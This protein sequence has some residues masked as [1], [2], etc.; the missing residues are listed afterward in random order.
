[1]KK[2]ERLKKDSRIFSYSTTAHGKKYGVNFYRTVQG[3]KISLRQ[4]GFTNSTDAIEWADEAER[5]IYLASGTAKRVTVSEYYS[6]WM[7]RNEAYWSPDTYN[8]YEQKFEKYLLPKFGKAKLRDV[9]RESF[10]NYIRELETVER[11]A[12]RIGYSSKTISTLRGYMSTMLNDAVYSG[13]IPS[14]KLR[15]LR[16]KAGIGVRNNEISKEKYVFAIKTAQRV[17][18]P[19]ALAAF[20]LSLVALRHAEILGMQPKNIYPDHVH[21][22]IARTHWK[23]EGGDTKTPAA[24]R[25]VPI[26]PRIYQLLQEAVKCSRQVYMDADK[27]F[28]SDS[29]IFVNENATPWSYTRLNH[30]FTDEVSAAMGQRVAVYES[31]NIFVD[32]KDGHRIFVRPDGFIGYKQ[33]PGK[34][35]GDPSQVKLLKNIMDELTGIEVANADGSKVIVDRSVNKGKARVQSVNA[36]GKVT[37][38]LIIPPHKKVVITNN[39]HIFPHMMRHAFATFSLPNAKDPIDVMKIMGHTDVRMTRFYDNGTKDGQTNIINM[40]DKLAE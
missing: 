14:N 18:S 32:D 37:D 1:M 11:G 31:G 23:P 27:Q 30:I 10:Q 39:A 5:E 12:G 29:F 9:T 21:V 8:N 22:E 16:V 17:L 15:N 40:M 2:E 7:A 19:M 24:V 28:A 33:A 38:D 25:D 36:Q 4:Q 20:Y 13:V 3:K 34:T 26:T 35:A 6:Q